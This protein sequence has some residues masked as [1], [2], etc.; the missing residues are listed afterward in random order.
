[1]NTAVNMHLRV[2]LLYM[3]GWMLKFN[4]IYISTY[5]YREVE[6]SIYASAYVLPVHY[7]NKNIELGG[8]RLITI[9]S[10]V[11]RELSFQPGEICNI[12]QCI[13]NF[14]YDMR[15]YANWNA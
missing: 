3:H 8:P 12:S 10:M 4:A 1:M 14:S 9:I 6:S 5:I 13:I 2:V 11:K 7:R 15:N